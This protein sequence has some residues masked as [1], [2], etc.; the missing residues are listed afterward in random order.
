LAGVDSNAGA[1]TAFTAS[2]GPAIGLRDVAGTVG[3]KAIPAKMAKELGVA[4]LS[5]SVQRL[6]AALAAWHLAEAVMQ[7]VESSSTLD[8]SSVVPTGAREA[9][10]MSNGP[11]AALPELLRLTRMAVQP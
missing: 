1:I 10:L 11:W 5:L 7:Q 8:L 6:M 4:D 3:A 9:W 2:V